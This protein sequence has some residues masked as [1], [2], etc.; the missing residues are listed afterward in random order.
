[1][2]K[3]KENP[4]GMKPSGY[5]MK[6]SPLELWPWSKKKKK[7]KNLVTGKTNRT[8]RSTGTSKRKSRFLAG[9]TFWN[10]RD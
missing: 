6:S 5:K 4:G 3:F 8:F 2:P 7:R 10:P 9:L 1:M